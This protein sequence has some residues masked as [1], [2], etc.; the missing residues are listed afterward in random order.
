MSGPEVG[1]IG[2][3]GG[4]IRCQISTAEFAGD[5]SL[6]Q[7]PE[8][9]PRIYVASLSDY[10]AGR[11]HGEWVNA[12]QEPDG[13]YTDIRLMLAASPMNQ[14]RSS[15]GEWEGRPEE[16]AIHDYDGFGRVGLGEYESVAKV[17]RIAA[18]IVEH[19][20]AFSDFVSYIGIDDDE[21][22]DE[23]EERYL[24]TWDS[25][26]AWAE[27]VL[28]DM[29]VNAEVGNLPNWVQPYVKI[30]VSGFARDCELGGDVVATA[31]A[32]YEA[33]SGGVR[34]FRG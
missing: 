28:D 5:G 9:V 30:D 16:W 32:S 14:M 25:L 10:N 18:G 23:F 27:E 21:G 13:I 33:G 7:G 22:I 6:E 26:E 3:I 12:N 20:P 2:A 29:G 1:S 17:S 34:V 24:G 15:D 11:L 4:E 19:G 31:V 8:S